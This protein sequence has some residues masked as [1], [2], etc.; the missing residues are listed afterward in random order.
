MLS[1]GMGPNGTV[2]VTE[3]VVAVGAAVA[4]GCLEDACWDWAHPAARRSAMTIT[5]KRNVLLPGMINHLIIKLNNDKI[6][7]LSLKK[8]IILD[9]NR[10][11]SSEMAKNHFI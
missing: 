3:G 8:D 5:M 11:F 10:I 7:G 1:T 2:I 9:R 6:I 4:G